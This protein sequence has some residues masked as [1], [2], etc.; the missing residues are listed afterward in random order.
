V[1]YATLLAPLPD[2][3]LTFFLPVPDSRPNNTEWIAAYYRRILAGIASV[4]DI[5]NVSAET[6][7]P[8]DPMQALRRE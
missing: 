3:A 8:L 2:H 7:T 5:S 6:G 1:D 4:T